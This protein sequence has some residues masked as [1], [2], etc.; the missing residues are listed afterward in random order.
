MENRYQKC[1][2]CKWRNISKP[3]TLQ[4]LFWSYF[5]LHGPITLCW[6]KIDFQK[7]CLGEMGNFL[8]PEVVMIKTWLRV[9]LVGMCKNEQIQFF[10]SQMYFS[11]ILTPWIWNIFFNH[12]GIYKFEEK[13]KKYSGEINLLRVHRN[14]RGC[15]F[16][17][18]SKGLGW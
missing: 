1:K 7:L 18:N 10:D 5:Q 11:V 2:G 16:E 12:G 4:V 9:L 14:I 6:G 13:I 15:I 17:V 3:V 8:L